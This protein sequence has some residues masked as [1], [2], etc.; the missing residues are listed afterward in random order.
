MTGRTESSSIIKRLHLA[1]TLRVF[2]FAVAVWAFTSIY[3]S[4]IAAE[5]VRA[6]PAFKLTLVNGTVVNSRDLQGKIVVIDFWG[7][8][9]KP[10]LTEIPAYNEFYRDYKAKGVQFFALAADSGA[11][12]E[13]REAARRLKID[14]PVGSPT[15][16]ELDLFGS[17]EAFPTT[18]IFDGRGKLVKDIVGTPPGKH[19]TIRQVVDQLLAAK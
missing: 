8:W 6:L 11:P 13:V 10:C 5:P 3:M 18:V 14:Y 19:A 2:L 7:T 1:K 15:W 16:D 4:P 9:C 12:A 17:I